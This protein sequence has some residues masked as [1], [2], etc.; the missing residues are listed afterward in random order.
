[1]FCGGIGVF[2]YQLAGLHHEHAIASNHARI[3]L[4][5][6]AVQR[7]GAASVT[8]QTPH[9]VLRWSWVLQPVATDIILRVELS[10]PHGFV[11]GELELPL[12]DQHSALSESGAAVW[13]RSNA[14]GRAV[15]AEAQPATVVGVRAV[16]IRGPRGSARATLVVTLDAGDYA[17]VAR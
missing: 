6:V 7:V 9:G 15:A 2:L 1:M 3:K 4:D 11:A 14:H 12:L 17:F 8:L 5:A 16:D 10:I 13:T